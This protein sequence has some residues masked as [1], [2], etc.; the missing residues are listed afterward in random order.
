MSMN[1]RDY[2]ILHLDTKSKKGTALL[3]MLKTEWFPVQ[4][5]ISSMLGRWQMNLLRLD[6]FCYTKQFTHV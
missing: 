3:L 4:N 2:P 1:M 6:I 5:V